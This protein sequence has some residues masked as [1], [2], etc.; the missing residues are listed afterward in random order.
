MGKILSAGARINRLLMPKVQGA[1]YDSQ[2]RVYGLSE[3]AAIGE[4]C[5]GGYEKG[6]SV[7]G[8][9]FAVVGDPSEGTC[10]VAFRARGIVNMSCLTG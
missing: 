4:R 7:Q 9:G 5:N 3:L 1:R 6:E 10:G 2:G 8:T